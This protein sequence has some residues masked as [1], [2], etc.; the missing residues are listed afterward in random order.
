VIYGD[1]TG[2][3]TWA[4]RGA[5]SHEDKSAYIRQMYNEF[6]R[7]EYATGYHVKYLCDGFVAFKEMV[8]GHNCG[9]ALCVLK[10]SYELQQRLE[11]LIVKMRHPRPEGFRVRVACGMVSKI[12]VPPIR[13]ADR[14][15]KV[16][17]VGFS[18]SLGDRILEVERGVG[19]ICTE[20]V[21]QLLKPDVK[22]LQFERL[23]IKGPTPRGLDDEDMKELYAFKYAN[24][25]APCP[26]G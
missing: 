26:N 9:G 21:R 1:T 12:W 7:Y 10:T 6:R 17:Y 16:E 2:F 8:R 20:A 13:K 4:K 24:G 23:L 3:T 15:W 18:P 5:T 19:C 22:S 14:R 25:D 11:A